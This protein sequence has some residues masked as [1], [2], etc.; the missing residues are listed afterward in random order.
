MCFTSLSVQ[1]II[2]IKQSHSTMR[3]NEYPPSCA[4]HRLSAFTL[5]PSATSRG[6]TWLKDLPL[7]YKCMLSINY[8]PSPLYRSRHPMFN[9]PV[10]FRVEESPFTNGVEWSN[11]P[12]GACVTSLVIPFW[13][14]SLMHFAFYNSKSCL[15]CRHCSAYS[16]MVVLSE[17]LRWFSCLLCV[18]HSLLTTQGT[19]LKSQ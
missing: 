13:E 3:T 6:P 16:F 14:I 11:L 18:N 5:L 9:Y 15:I 19:P 7:R 10:L 4:A 8:Y 17:I 2:Q 12:S 1:K